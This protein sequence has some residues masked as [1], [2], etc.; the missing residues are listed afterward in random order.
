MRV[1]RRGD[2]MFYPVPAIKPAEGDVKQAIVVLTPAESKRLLAKAVAALPEVQRAYRSG[3]L[4][5]TAGSTNAF[6]VLELTGEEIPPYR[7]CVGMNADSVLTMSHEED[8]I[9]GRFYEQGTEVDTPYPEFMKSLGRGDVVIKGGNAIDP[10]GNVGVLLSNDTGGGVGAT[11]GVASARGI[12]VI[13]PIGFEKQ[14][15]SVPD[16]AVGWGQLTLDYSMGVRV[17]MASLTSVQAVTERE[18]LAVL[19]G[20]SARHVASG[21]IG[22]NEGAVVI[23]LEGDA[24]RVDKALELIQGIKGAPTLEVPRHI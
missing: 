15:A 10:A 14:I 3:R 13:T 6:V 24:G 8:R 19:E 18:G 12:T 5:I 21:G 9:Y 4:A 7:F 11:F 22:G 16:A 17:G 2:G 1:V 23:L 20:V